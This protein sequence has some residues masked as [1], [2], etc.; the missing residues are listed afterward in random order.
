FFGSGVLRLCWGG[1]VGRK[2]VTFGP[3]AA[4]MALRSSAV[5][6]SKYPSCSM[7]QQYNLTRTLC[8]VQKRPLRRYRLKLSCPY[9][10]G[11][12]EVAI[13]QIFW[14]SSGCWSRVSVVMPRLTDRQPSSAVGCPG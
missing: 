13:R 4:A 10:P 7:H 9:E 12:F 3:V 14:H 6:S 2:I 8:R 5:M 11:V 1:A